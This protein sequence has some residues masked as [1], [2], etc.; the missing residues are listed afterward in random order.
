[1]SFLAAFFLVR[2]RLH[3]AAKQEVKLEL[4]DKP[5]TPDSDV[6]TSVLMKNWHMEEVGPFGGGR[7]PIHLLKYLHTLCMW[8]SLLGFALALA[9]A[10]CFTWEQLTISAGVFASI[11]MG[12]SWAAALVAFLLARRR[13]RGNTRP[14]LHG[15]CLR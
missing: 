1:M 10:L 15:H 9:G 3:E 12:V 4:G 5:G 7:P 8:L 14:F 2:Y 11:C 13:E 6:K